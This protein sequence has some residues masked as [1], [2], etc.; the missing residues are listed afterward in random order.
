M[1][2]VAW[3]LFF[4]FCLNYGNGHAQGLFDFGSEALSQFSRGKAEQDEGNLKEAILW[5]KKAIQTDSRHFHSYHNIGYIYGSKGFHEQAVKWYKRAVKENPKFVD[6]LSNLGASYIE[7]GK[8]DL[9]VGVLKEANRIDPDSFLVASN[10]AAALRGAGDTDGAERILEKFKDQKIL[11]GL[12]P[13]MRGKQY[14]SRGDFQG[15][16]KAYRFAI[17]TSPSNLPAYSNLGSLLIKMKKF[18]DAELVLKEATKMRNADYLIHL[19]LGYVYLQKKNPREAQ[20]FCEK[21]VKMNPNSALG[22]SNLGL[23][24]VRQGEKVGTQRA[25][26]RALKIDPKNQQ[27]RKNLQAIGVINDEEN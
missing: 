14:E 17:K 7:L 16:I 23:A 22:W 15:A 6:S 8:N 20:R 12:D 5:Y 3:N 19:N 13:L 4:I 2:L 27:I 26:E 9:A 11:P 1:R 21:A 10:Y 18:D 25:W 24:L